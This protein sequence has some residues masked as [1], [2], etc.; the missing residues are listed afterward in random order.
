MDQTPGRLVSGPLRPYLLPSSYRV[1][2]LGLSAY[3]LTPATAL[4][5][6]EFE[7][8]CL[9]PCRLVCG[10]LQPYLSPAP[11]CPSLLELSADIGRPVRLRLSDGRLV[12]LADEKLNIQEQVGCTA[13]HLL[14][15][16][17]APC[18]ASS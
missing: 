3:T 2:L 1:S 7:T 17:L 8:V 16:V 11:G 15:A 10:P 5:L 9:I 13:I 14:Q 6:Y 12:E 18:S 4:L